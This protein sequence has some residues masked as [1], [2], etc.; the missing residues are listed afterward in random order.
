M[1]QT[2]QKILG[3]ILDLITEGKSPT[4]VNRTVAEEF[5]KYDYEKYFR[6]IQKVQLG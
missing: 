5:S 1:T 2:S 4:E 3:R 6:E